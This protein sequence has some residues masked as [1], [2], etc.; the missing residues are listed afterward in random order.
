MEYA[1]IVRMYFQSTEVFRLELGHH[2]TVM[3]NW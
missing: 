1:V 2:M 3:L